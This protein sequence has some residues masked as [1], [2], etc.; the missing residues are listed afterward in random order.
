MS[1]ALTLCFPG[2]L[3]E[4]LGYIV[5]KENFYIIPYSSKDGKVT[6]E[7]GVR[8]KSST[9]FGSMTVEEVMNLLLP[10]R[11]GGKIDILFVSYFNLHYQLY[12]FIMPSLFNFGLLIKA[13]L[14]TCPHINMVMVTACS[15]C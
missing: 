15:K 5:I 11:L 1:E 2:N 10:D 9:S 6:K 4:V 8:R 3:I 12:V 14:K 7:K 13:K